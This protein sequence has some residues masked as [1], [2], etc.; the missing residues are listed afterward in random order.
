MEQNK[1]LVEVREDSFFARR[2][3]ITATTTQLQF[4]KF[5][6]A[7]AKPTVYVDTGKRTEDG[8]E[9]WAARHEEPRPAERDALAVLEAADEFEIDSLRWAVRQAIEL[10]RKAPHTA[11][12]QPGTA[13]G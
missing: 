7:D 8:L 9:I 4:L 1:R 3:W 12:A 2:I 11:A 6:K 13:A 5:G 10:L